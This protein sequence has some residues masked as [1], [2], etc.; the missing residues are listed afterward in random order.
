MDSP[1]HILCAIF[2]FGEFDEKVNLELPRQFGSS[3]SDLPSWALHWLNFWEGLASLFEGF[4]LLLVNIS[5]LKDA[6]MQTWDAKSGKILR[7]FHYK[8]GLLHHATSILLWLDV[9]LH[10]LLVLYIGF[11]YELWVQ[12]GWWCFSYRVLPLPMRIKRVQSDQTK[13]AQKRPKDRK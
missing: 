13:R 5:N 11:S 3:F 10:C 6:M 7:I 1:I 8:L 2:G 9:I 12:K 4:Q